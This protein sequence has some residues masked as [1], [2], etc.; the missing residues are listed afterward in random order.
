MPSWKRALACDVLGLAVLLLSL[1]DYFRPGL[2]LL[3]TIAAGGDTPCHFPTAVFF[4]EHLLPHLRHHGWFPGAYMGHPLLLYYFP[5]PFLFM[6]GVA[7]IV[8]L[9]A[10]RR[11]GPFTGG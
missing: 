10:P 3:P 7:P 5:L 1:L 2:L 11:W 9:P 8:G 4:H 6:S